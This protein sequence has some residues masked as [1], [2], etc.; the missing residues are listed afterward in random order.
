MLLRRNIMIVEPPDY[1]VKLLEIKVRE[2]LKNAS[3]FD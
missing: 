2:D 3:I 1:L